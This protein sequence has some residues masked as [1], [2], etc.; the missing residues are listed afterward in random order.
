MK[1]PMNVTVITGASQGLGNALA[2]ACARAG[3]NLVLLSLPDEGLLGIATVLES[4]YQIKV[5]A[6]ETDLTQEDAPEAFVNWLSQQNICVT[7]L[8]NNAGIGGTS[9][10]DQT[11]PDF[12]NAII[13]LNIRALAMLTRLLIP[14]LL[15]NRRAYI[16]NISS[17]AAFSPIPYKSVYPASKAFVYYFSMGLREELRHTGIR[18]S[19]MHPGPMQT[20][21]DTSKRIEKQGAFAKWSVVQVEEIASFTLRQMQRGR[22]IIIPGFINKVSYSLMSIIPHRLQTPILARIFTK[23][24]PVHHVPSKS[25]SH[26]SYRFVG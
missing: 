10:F 18:V 19:V 6:Y 13:L 9:A 26:R 12:I 25:A 8:I 22:A 16:L 21:R 3:K 1:S 7:T 4:K 17:M 24:L 20:N 23:E 5:F 15:Q 14:M 11:S 2:T